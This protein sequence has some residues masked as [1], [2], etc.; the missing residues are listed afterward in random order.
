MR[1]RELRPQAPGRGLREERGLR[2][3]LLRRRRLL[4]RRLSGRLRGLQ[5]GRT[6]RDVLAHRPRRRR[7]ARP[8]Q[9]PRGRVVRPHGHVRWLRRL[10][11]L[12]RRDHLHCPRVRGRSS[13]DGRHLQRHRG[14]PRPRRAGVRA[15]PL[16]ERRLQDEVCLRRRLPGRAR[17]RR[18]ELRP[19]AERPDL[20]RGRRM[21]EHLLRRRRLLRRRVSGRLPVLRTAVG[22]GSLHARPRGRGRPA[23]HLRRPRR[24][25]LRHRRRL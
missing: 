8:V 22:D 1:R 7:P 16:H 5:P 9:G 20:R 19:Q 3:G 10:C 24:G 14:V 21:R 12:S 6:R 11:A 18:G 2:L 25:H 17:L 15:V 13:R 4:Q 23:R